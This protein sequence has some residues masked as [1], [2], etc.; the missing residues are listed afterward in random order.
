MFCDSFLPVFICFCLVLFHTY[1]LNTVLYINLIVQA[2]ILPLTVPENY[3]CNPQSGRLG[4]LTFQTELRHSSVEYIAPSEYMVREGGEEEERRRGRGGEREVERKLE[5]R[6]GGRR[7]G[8][9]RG[10]EGKEGERKER[11]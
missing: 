10:A 3:D 8:S 4:D 5:G 2:H 9:G 6:E 7:E 1:I 11:K